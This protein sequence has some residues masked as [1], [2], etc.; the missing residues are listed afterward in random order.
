MI[1]SSFNMKK[2]FESIFLGIILGFLP[3]YINAQEVV[4]DI[5][6][7]NWEK[8][9]DQGNGTY[10]NP[11]LPGDYSDIDCIRVGKDYYAISSTFQFSPGMVI[12]H[13][14]DLVNWSILGHAV[15]DLSQIS[16][17]LNWDKMDSY[18]KGIWAGSIRHHAGKFWIYFGTPDEGYFMT[19]SKNIKGPWTPLVK[20]LAEKGWD[21]CC[22]FWDDDG[23]SYLVGTHFSEGYK[24]H[25]FQMSADGQRIIGGSD[26][27]FYQS[28]GSEANKLYKING[29]YYHFFSEVK[30]DGRVVMIRKAKSIKGPYGAPKQIGHAQKQFNE[31]NQGGIINTAGGKWYFLTHHGS[32][33]D[34]SGRNMS[35][36]P[37]NWVDGWP[38]LGR[39]GNDTIG[40]MVWVDK[41]PLNTLTRV[42]PSS[43][44]EFNDSEITTQWEWNYQPRIDKFSLNERKGWLRLKAFRPLEK[45]NLLKA[46][47]TITQRSMRTLRSEA[48]AKLDISGMR[49]GQ[50]SGITHFGSPTYSSFGVSQKTGERR[51]ELNLKNSINVGPIIKS[52]QIWLKSIWGL[53]GRSQY[54][55]STDGENFIAFGEPYLLRWGSYRGDRIGIFNYNNDDD[56]GYVDIDYFR[57]SF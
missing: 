24:I 29:M 20:V 25:L 26:E 30:S 43:S 47:N 11:I 10:R 34:W 49:D 4:Q 57:Y 3:L 51:I 5:K 18:G 1:F 39:V 40:N 17:K 23:Q 37:V 42:V 52:N 8:W 38:I 9:G 12:L 53:D 41:K 6:W 54:Y 16:P 45:N 13:S 35:L 27:V 46:G 55:Y 7:G 32:S 2:L 50:K 48:V 44:D 33:G 31:P 28:K 22:P 15:N 19:S 36:L 21:D 56:S 14:R